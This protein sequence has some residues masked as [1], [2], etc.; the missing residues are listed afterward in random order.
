MIYDQHPANDVFRKVGDD[1]VVGVMDVRG[2][3]PFYFAMQRDN[4]LPVFSSQR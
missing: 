4:S 1:A 2:Q 3:R